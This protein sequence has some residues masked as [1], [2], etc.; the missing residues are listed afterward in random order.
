[1][2][3]FS[4]RMKKL[5]QRGKNTVEVSM[6]A[7]K[8]KDTQDTPGAAVTIDLRS[9]TFFSPRAFPLKNEKCALSSSKGKV[10]KP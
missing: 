3:V 1:M 7:L 9:T 10:R 6:N 5:N 2:K 4:Q 8:S